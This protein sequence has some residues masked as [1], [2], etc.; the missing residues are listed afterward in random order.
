MIYCE[1]LAGDNTYKLRL[2]IR[3][4]VALEKSIGCNPLMIFGDGSTVP[5]V[6]IMVQILHASL[7]AYHHNITMNEAYDIF[8]AFLDDGHQI[9][10]FIPVILDIY[11]VSGIMRDEKSE[12]N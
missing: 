1:F 5:T 7:Q 6:S 3:Q 8:D 12:K 10:D 9:T 4:I 2:P 11:R